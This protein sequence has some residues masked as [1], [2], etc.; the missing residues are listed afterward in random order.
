[1]FTHILKITL[2]N[3]RKNLLFTLIIIFGL[4]ISMATILVITR[5]VIQ[6]YSTDKFHKEYNNIFLVLNISS[7][8]NGSAISQDWAE[9][10][11]SGSINNIKKRRPSARWY[12][13]L[14]LLL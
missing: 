12:P 1:M 14:P 6:E 7:D 13:F 10:I 9:K 3:Y 8:D 2:R 5:Y 4:A 11:K